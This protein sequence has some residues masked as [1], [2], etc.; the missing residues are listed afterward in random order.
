MEISINA[1]QS[2]STEASP[3]VS[4]LS[5]TAEAD[6]GGVYV[7]EMADGKEPPLYEITI[8]MQGGTITLYADGDEL[9]ELGDRIIT[10]GLD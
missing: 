3:N 1:A 8:P 6:S 5:I 2:D 10:V 9:R 7:S 4:E